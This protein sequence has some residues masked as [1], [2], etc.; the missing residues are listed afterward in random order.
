MKKTAIITGS[1]KGIGAATAILFAQ[2]GYNIV[3]TYN[4]SYESATLLA[5]SLA[6][7]GFSVTAQKL[8]VA[9]RLE[10]ELLVKETLY[11]YGSIDVLVNNAG[12]A[13]QGLITQTDEIDYDRI[14]DINLKGAFNCCKAVTPVMVNQQSGKIINIS[15]MWGETGAS[16]EVAYSASKAG[17]IGLTKAL[18]KELAPSGITVNAVTPGLIETSMN[19]NLSVEELNDFVESIPLGR[20]GTADEVAQAIYFLA[21]ENADYITG[22]I[23]G[24]NG[25]YVI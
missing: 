13:F 20:M 2:K 9:N 1:S 18:A 7:N 21:S 25:G 14:L 12:V 3:I 6:S 11:K 15:S 24:V 16:C 5:R 8:N 10:V 4:E 22:Q 19:S 23:L 17:I